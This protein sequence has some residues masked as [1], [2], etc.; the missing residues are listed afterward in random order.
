LAPDI[1]GVVY[2]NEGAASAGEFVRVQITEAATYD[3]VGRLVS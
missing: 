3:L 2:V 1:D